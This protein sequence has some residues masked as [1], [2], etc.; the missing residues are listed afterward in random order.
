MIRP[1]LR[2]NCWQRVL[3]WFD[4]LR[5]LTT[6]PSE[7]EGPPASPTPLRR[8]RSA[9]VPS[10]SRAAGTSRGTQRRGFHGMR[11][12]G[13]PS[14][15]RIRRGAP[16]PASPAA[17]GLGSS[18][19]HQ[20]FWCEGSLGFTLVELLVTTSLMALV[21]GA[22]VAALSGGLRVWERAAET[23]TGQESL[24]IAFSQLRRDL[25]N[26]RAFKLVPFDGAY[27]RFTFA[28]ADVEHPD[29]TGPREVGQRGYYLDEPHHILCR[30][31]VPYRL[32]RRERI[33]DRCRTVLE[34]VTRVR[35]SYFGTDKD[36]GTAG[37]SQHWRSTEAPIAVK[38]EL[39]IQSD[40]RQPAATHPFI[41]NLAVA[42][43]HETAQ[44]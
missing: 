14:P 35:F 42:P 9:F 32:M 31:Y 21:G 7:V 24:L 38:A 20:S 22:A 41:I 8:L 27:D 12:S 40:R 34:G 30:A 44:P 3:P 23:G 4:S 33:T 29:A 25:Q 37:W 2:W 11:E 19:P 6:I 18:S 17:Y 26:V 1:T 15:F 39:V 13:P 36:S 5:S 43:T 28:T 10:E 16:R